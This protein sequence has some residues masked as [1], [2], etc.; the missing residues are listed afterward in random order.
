M[1][2]RR[3]VVIEDEDDVVYL[4]THWDG[5]RLV[6]VVKSAMKRGN[7]RWA[8]APYLTRIIFSEMIKDDVNGETG[9]GISSKYMDSERD[10]IIINITE[11]SVKIGQSVKSFEEFIS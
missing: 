9:Y 1:G 6:D 11:Q 10:D 5:Y 7:S 4:Y 8:D 2:D 3:Q